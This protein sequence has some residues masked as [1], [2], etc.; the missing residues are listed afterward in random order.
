[1]AYLVFARKYRP[2]T[3]AQV[4]KQEHVTQTLQ[5]AIEAGRLAHAIL[6]AGPRGTGKTTIARILAKAVNCLQGPAKE[7]CNKCRSCQEITTSAAA[8]VF[9]IDGASNNSVDQVRELR[10]NL[11]YMP[12][13]SRFKIYIIDEVHML[14]T[15][16][17]N[18]LLKT[19]EEPP[20]HVMFMFATTEPHKIPITIL[21]RCQRHDLRRI[22]T[23]AIV[24]HMA[25]ICR[26]EN[27]DF[28]TRSLV[29]IA[30]CADGSM[31][32]ALSLLDQVVAS[33]SDKNTL[34]EVTRMLAMTDIRKVYEMAGA[35]L[36][37]DV[38]RALGLLAEVHAKGDD[39]QRFYLEL[40]TA[41]RHMSVL[42]LGRQARSLVD[43][44]QDE[45]EE[46]ERLA[47]AADQARLQQV[48]DSLVGSE[49]MVKLAAQPRLAFEMV[50]V[51]L[52]R[53]PPIL[54]IET[55]IEKIDQMGKAMAGA[56]RVDKEEGR[57]A[58]SKA[59]QTAPQVDDFADRQV[60]KRAWKRVVSM[61]GRQK[62]SLGVLLEKSVPVSLQG[63]G[64]IVKV[65]G[66]GFAV[67]SVE[68]H[69]GL[70]ESKAG[71][72]LGRVVSLR[73]EADIESAEQKKKQKAAL[74]RSKQEALGHPL[75]ADALE[76]FNG[77]IYDV[78]VKQ[79]NTGG[80]NP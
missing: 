63:Q 76:V 31:R 17:F 24:D 55:L 10:E 59:S 20:A 4:V 79:N 29:D 39:L 70:I 58:D 42:R 68:K 62:P 56:V 78:R 35:I 65:K 13:Y 14:S 5:N 52:S 50:L 37:N 41:F 22:E 12:A 75:V 51:R 69:K 48:F 66:N 3:F 8:D 38:A 47:S 19:L 71:K 1:M 61:V 45:I 26:Q 16:A 18:A 43:L 80:S 21:S 46:L 15:A 77:K 60:L 9:E 72:V 40:A 27:V 25:W 23:Q 36:Q 32:D 2:Q 6:F 33:A 64:L 28:E 30:R 73:V 34:S 7:P 11:K 44:P 54:P 53:T 49:A 67:K 74:Q 57:P